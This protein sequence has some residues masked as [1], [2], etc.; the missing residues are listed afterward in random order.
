MSASSDKRLT[1]PPPEGAERQTTKDIIV[2]LLRNLGSRKEVEQ[3]VRQYSTVE[4]QK[5][6]LIKVGGGLLAK[7]LDGLASSL[8]FLHSV[9]LYPIV[10][11]GAGPQLTD[12][13]AEA[14]I[15]TTAREDGTR[16]ITPQVLEVARKVMLRE[17]LRLVEALEQMG[18]RAR[19]VSA[20]VFEAE[21][22]DPRELGFAGKVTQVHLDGVQSSIRAGHL[23]ILTSLGVT[24]GGQ[25]V[26]I[27]ADAAARELAIAIQPFKMIFLTEP[28]GLLDEHGRVISAVNLAEDY[29]HLMSQPWLHSGMRHKMQEI[30]T[31]LDALP[32]T[33]SISV[34]SPDHLAKELFT[35]TGSGTLVRRG[36]RVRVYE[37]L[38]GIDT[39]RLRDL[40]EACF[41]RKLDEK[42]F[43]K[44][45]IYR[46]Y[47][48]DSYR[49]TAIITRDLQIPYLDKFA[50][51]AQAQGAGVGGSLWARMKAE[52]PKLFWRSRV[53]NEIN[54]WYF[55][56]SQGSYKSDRWTVF[57]YG[58]ESFEEIKDCIEHALSLPATLREHGTAEV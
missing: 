29:A 47:L 36:D 12:A 54:P 49:A 18:T 46:V 48:A 28:G 24:P 35:H 51:T 43:D 22:I 15:E 20:S 31:I 58:L 37:S 56:Q 27:N 53:E 3:Y 23:P 30:K 45:I 32:P 25:I 38:E 5:F 26:S 39:E 1:M 52:N 19:P 57:W 10:I 33:S 17:N 50:V 7:D 41:Q 34:T 6:A 4:T 8:T 16:A 21:L 13:L 2:K 44:K 42:Y 40:L 9:G 14:H 55:Q 11:H